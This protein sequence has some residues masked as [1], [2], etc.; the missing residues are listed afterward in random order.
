MSHVTPSV[1]STPTGVWLAD[2]ERPRQEPFEIEQ[3]AMGQWLLRLQ[4]GTVHERVVP[5]RAFP[6]ASPR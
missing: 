5:V 1:A 4:D 2:D 6:I 3:D